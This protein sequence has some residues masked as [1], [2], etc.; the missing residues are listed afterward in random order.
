MMNAGF[1][2]TATR[3]LER[4]AERL[5][6]ALA[7][8]AEVDYEGGI[9]TVTLDE[10][11]T[12]V[13]NKHAPTQQVWLSSPRSGAWHFALDAAAGVWRDTRQ[14]RELTQLLSDELQAATGTAV[15]LD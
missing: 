8:V 10:G 3:M 12:Y 9:L 11:G 1:D 6:T 15:A 2:L 7:D 5:E 14:G 4:F 13:I